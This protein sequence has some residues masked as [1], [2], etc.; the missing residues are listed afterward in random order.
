MSL[1]DNGMPIMNIMNDL[2][3]V[4]NR[5]ADVPGLTSALFNLLNPV[6]LASS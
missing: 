2:F 3:I 4:T 6:K 1:F 5:L